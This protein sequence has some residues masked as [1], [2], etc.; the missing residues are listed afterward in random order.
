VEKKSPLNPWEGK[1]MP[2]TKTNTTVRKA[3]VLRKVVKS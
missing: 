2:K 3:T 1:E